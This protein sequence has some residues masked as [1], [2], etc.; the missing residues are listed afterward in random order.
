MGCKWR[1][2]LLLFKVI[3]V[4]GGEEVVCFDLILKIKM[5]NKYQPKYN[6]GFIK[7]T[8]NCIL[9]V[10]G[11]KLIIIFKVYARYLQR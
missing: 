6:F 3:P 8:L 7:S 10:K 11:E 9:C 1:R 2:D 5:K 4:D